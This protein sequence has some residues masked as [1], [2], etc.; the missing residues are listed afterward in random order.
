SMWYGIFM[1]AFTIYLVYWSIQR[2]HTY[3]SLPWPQDPPSTALNAYISLVGS[4]VVVLPL[5][6]MATFFKIGNL[7]NDGLKL[8]SS[9]SACSQDPPPIMKPSSNKIRCG[10]LLMLIKLVYRF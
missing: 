7:A 6:L 3:S 2:F 4:S 9:L 5:F 10:L 8:G 1:T